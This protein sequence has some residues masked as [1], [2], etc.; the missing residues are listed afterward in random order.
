MVICGIRPWASN[1][2]PREGYF[3]HKPEIKKFHFMNILRFSVLSFLVLIAGC[4]PT[5][6]LGSMPK[7][8]SIPDLIPGVTTSSEVQSILGE[9]TAKGSSLWSIAPMTPVKLWEYEFTKTDGV[10]SDLT[11]VMI[12][13]RDDRFEGYLWF[14]AEQEY[15]SRIVSDKVEST[16]FP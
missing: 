15:K 8:A 7:I 3:L 13:F 9:P 1:K 2:Q 6:T 10:K 12:F 14:S 5:I 4:A 16:V 11:I